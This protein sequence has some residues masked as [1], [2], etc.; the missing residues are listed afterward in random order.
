MSE[1]DQKSRKPVSLS[2]KIVIGLILGIVT[3]LVFGEY[4]S[5][6]SVF[7]D[8]FIGLLQM[9]VLPY[10]V[11]SLIVNIGRLS[12]EKGKVLIINALKVLVVLILFG[13][14]NLLVLQLSFPEWK[15]S[16]FFSLSFIETPESIDFLKLYIPS[17]PFYSLSNNQVPAVVLFSIILGVAFSRIQG[18]DS[19]L[20]NL[21][22]LCNA[23]N[24]VNKIVI[25]L[26]PLGVFAI[27]AS[28][29]GTIS[30]GE[31]AK[32]QTYILT[33]TVAVCIMSFWVLPML[34]AAVTPFKYSDIFKYTRATLLTIF[35]TGKII[36][37]LPQLIANIDELFKS[38]N[39][40][41]EE[42]DS[43]TDILMPLAYPFPN[44]G[45]LII[46][47]FI[48]FAAW[49]AGGSLGLESMPIFVGAGFLSSFIAPVT[50]IPFMLNLLDVP[51]DQFQLF[52]ISTVYTDRIRVVLGAI[53]LI[54]LTTIATSMTVGI[55][56][57]QKKK[58]AVWGL[59]SI[60]LYVAT[61]FPLR[62]YLGY[63]LKDAYQY[64]RIISEMKPLYKS[65]VKV[66]VL[67]KPKKNP[68][69]IMDWQSKVS[70]IRSTG[71]LRV[72]YVPDFLPFSYFNKSGELVG[73]DIEMA[74][75]LA[76]SLHVNLVFVPVVGDRYK[77]GLERD[78]YD[79]VMSGIPLS[80]DLAEE[81]MVSSSY[82]DVTMAMMAG[83]RA[84]DF[85][86]FE[87]A[88]KL[89]TFKIAY[90][91]REEFVKLFQTY[92][93]NSIPVKIDSLAEFIEK[94]TTIADG[95]LVAAE[96]GSYQTLLHPEYQ[97]VNPLP[98]N[99]VVP[100]VYPIGNES[101]EL[102][103]YINNWIIIN[104]KQGK[105]RELYDYWILGKQAM[106]PEKNWSVLKDVFHVGE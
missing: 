74:K 30:W 2:G 13:L 51:S 54:T 82:M 93:P 72:G 27:A 38:N 23:L 15:S 10:I 62:S 16:S 57:V 45:T 105:T 49:Y 103:D 34:I 29:I 53:H 64:D 106:R 100:L 75:L 28:T 86:D 104:A 71:L 9:T 37:V 85:K 92:L 55:Y 41:S 90:L 48:P 99:V 61:L 76:E 78:H 66:T 91:Y 5:W 36:V 84:N 79:I 56:K 4:A 63:T 102:R 24:Q 89:D 39:L 80:S 42:T 44:L 59:V 22:I 35:A 18:K 19:L 6:L 81:V 96:S 40:R 17:N 52:F 67:K 65:D 3:G 70:R 68:V 87:S 8:A 94:D 1:P 97:I 95:L 26:T 7:G 32:I 25:K 31:L 12:L 83:L 11:F 77:R 98:V 69:K 50:G 20:K 60:L 58:L 101:Q 21:D 88:S 43:A 73:L 14:L 33:Y 47:I 46:F